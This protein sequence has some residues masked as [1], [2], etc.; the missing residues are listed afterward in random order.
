M[1]REA[2]FTLIE[3]LVA[4]ALTSMIAVAGSALLT[5]TLRASGR[6]ND[7]SASTLEADLSH[8]L[9]RDDFANIV[10]DPGVFEGEYLIEKMETKAG[11]STPMP[12]EDWTSGHQSMCESF[13]TSVAEDEAPLSDGELGLEV[14]KVV[15][16]AY[17]SAVEGRRIDL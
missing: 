12:D 1:K 17:C 11:W 5:S 2:G 8:T 15:Y 6:L 3:M 16:S 4:L 10:D 14:V 9:M 7:V 13:V